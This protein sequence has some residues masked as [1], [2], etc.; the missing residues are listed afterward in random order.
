MAEHRGTNRGRDPE[1]DGRDHVLSVQ[2]CQRCDGG[3]CGQTG[4]E[5]ARRDGRTDQT[6]TEMGGDRRGKCFNF[7]FNIIKLFEC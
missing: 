2:H 1:A 6:Q 3:D 5:P 7:I 4:S